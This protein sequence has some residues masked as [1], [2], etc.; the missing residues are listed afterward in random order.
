[1][2]QVHPAIAPAR[3][4]AWNGFVDQIATRRARCRCAL[5][6]RGRLTRRDEQE[7]DRLGRHRGLACLMW[8]SFSPSKP[9]ISRSQTTTSTSSLSRSFS[10]LMPSTASITSSK[11]RAGARASRTFARELAESSMMS[12]LGKQPLQGE[13]SHLPCSAGR[14]GSLGAGEGGAGKKRGGRS[15]EIRRRRAGSTPLG[16]DSSGV[17]GFRCARLLAETGSE[18]GRAGRARRS[19]DPVGIRSR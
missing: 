2:L 12:S 19:E 17:A 6:F 4:G 10:P 16:D 15:L 1:M 14:G 3:S 8:R 7:G 9:G 5:R 18:P 13:R 11:I